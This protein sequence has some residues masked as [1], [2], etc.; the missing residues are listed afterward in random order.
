MRMRVGISTCVF[1]LGCRRTVESVLA[2]CKTGKQDIHVVMDGNRGYDRLDKMPEYAALFASIDQCTEKTDAQRLDS[3]NGAIQD[4]SFLKAFEE[5]GTVRVIRNE[6]NM[7]AVFTF[8]RVLREGLD[9]DIAVLITDD[10]IVLPGWSELIEK[11][12]REFPNIVMAG[13]SN[14][15]ANAWHAFEEYPRF[16]D[17]MCCTAFRTSWLKELFVERGYVFHPRYKML[18]ADVQLITEITKRGHD[19]GF[20]ANP[21]LVDSGGHHK[22]LGHWQLANILQDKAQPYVY[23]KVLADVRGNHVFVAF[24]GNGTIDAVKIRQA[25]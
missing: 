21:R 2:G 20:I 11:V 5:N 13:Y 1:P 18:N 10:E 15:G 6:R 17:L 22:S 19:I 7:G 16:D 9:S 12:F 25:G 3:D 8:N 4:Y 24:K 23:D 14:I